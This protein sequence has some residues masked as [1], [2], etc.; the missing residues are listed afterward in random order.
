[1][2]DS[3]RVVVDGTDAAEPKEGRRAAPLLL[4]VGL[5]AV[6]G[7]ALL[8]LGYTSGDDEPVAVSTS[9]GEASEPTS[10][11]YGVTALSPEFPDAIVAVVSG[12]R[13]TVDGPAAVDH[14][15]WPTEA[16]EVVSL[17]LEAPQ[18]GPSSLDI[19][20]TWVVVSSVDPE[21]SLLELTMGRPSS[22]KSIAATA[23]S[24]AWHDSAQGRLSFSVVE[25]GVWEL[26]TATGLF[27][28]DTIPTDIPLNGLGFVASW[29]DWGWAIQDYGSSSLDPIVWVLDSDG[30]LIRSIPGIAHGS[31][32][33]GLLVVADDSTVRVVRV[34]DGTTAA[35]DER[36]G[37]APIAA[38][39]I[40]PDGSR[41]VFL[42]FDG[43]TVMTLND[44]QVVFQS[45]PVVGWAQVVWS[46]DSRFVMVPGPTGVSIID[47]AT[48]T[49]V[50]G[51][52]GI[53]V[54]SIG[55]IPLTSS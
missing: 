1:M 21:T 11:R 54:R 3:S 30:V 39:S 41:A 13:T 46:S 37:S 16:P 36:A 31:H 25:E 28:P 51:F 17:L 6:L 15:L 27:P 23:N 35:F 12:S 50:E 24:F 9:A 8:L 38:A 29:G 40:S 45:E 43:L 19:T 49:V 32:P 48:S 5:V 22:L 42:D 53:V 34:S 7:A 55:V 4:T 2:P 18:L 20:G 33:S 52:A 14:I 44:S 10:P 47:T 26:R